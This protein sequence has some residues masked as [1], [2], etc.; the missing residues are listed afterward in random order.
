MSHAQCIKIISGM[1]YF[2][3]MHKCTLVHCLRGSLTEYYVIFPRN[4]AKENACIF[5][6]VIIIVRE[7]LNY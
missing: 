4:Q 7:Y 5:E 2:L 3:F 6:I 1:Q